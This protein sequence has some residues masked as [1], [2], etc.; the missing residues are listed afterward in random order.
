MLPGEMHHLDVP[1]EME[2]EGGPN[3]SVVGNGSGS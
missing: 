3:A 2:P 1:Q